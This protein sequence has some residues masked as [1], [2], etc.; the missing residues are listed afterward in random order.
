MPRA[1]PAVRNAARDL[2][3][4]ARP[5]VLVALR[6]R[7][8]GQAR[9]EAARGGRVGPLAQDTLGGQPLLQQ[10]PRRGVVAPA[11]RRPP[12]AEGRQGGRLPVPQ[13]PGDGQ[14]LLEKGTGADLI[15]SLQD[16]DAGA[17]ERPRPRRRAQDRRGRRPR[18]GQ[19]LG[20]AP[21]ALGQVPPQVP[22]AR[23]RRAQ[24][25]GPRRRR[26]VP[27]GRPPHLPPDRGPQVAVLDLQSGEPHR[28]RRPPQ[29]RGRRLRQPQVVGRVPPGDRLCLP[30]RHQPLQGVLP[31]RL[32][33]LEAGVP[34]AV[35]LGEHQRAVDQ[36][37][38]PVQH[39]A[40]RDEP[41]PARRCSS[42]RAHRVGRGRRIGRHPLRRR[43][44][45]AAGEDGQAPEEGPLRLG[46]QGVAPV[47]RRGQGLL[48]GERGAAPA[49]QQAEAV[50]Q[51]TQEVPHRQD[52]RAGGGQLQGQGDPV[53]P[54]AQLGH[55]PRVL[56]AQ[57]EARPGG[58]GALHE[59]SHRLVRG[60]GLRRVR[61]LGRRLQGR[62]APD[63]LTGHPQRLAAR[64][65]DAHAR[66]GAQEGVRQRGAGRHEVLAV[67]Q[68]QQQ[69]LLRQ[70]RRERGRRGLPGTLADAQGARHGLGDEGRVGQR[71]QLDQPHPARVPGQGPLRDLQGEARLAGAPGAGDRQQR[72][73]LEA[74]RQLRERRAAPDEA[75]RR[76]RQVA[77]PAAPRARP[78]RGHAGGSIGPPGGLLGAQ[79]L[80]ATPPER[81]I[82]P[83]AVSE[84]AEDR[85]GLLHRRAD[86]AAVLVLA[87]Q[88]APGGKRPRD[89]PP[90]AEGRR[91]RG[92]RSRCRA[93][94]RR[95]RERQPPPAPARPRGA[96]PDRRGAPRPGRPPPRPRPPRAQGG[97]CPRPRGR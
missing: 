23:Q 2:S 45:P 75:A 12:Q 35:L 63:R 90:V 44:R 11:D 80:A 39:A 42:L 28:P 54:A 25:H 26:R 87:Q 97:S 83:R 91:Q 47:H 5:R 3:W 6:H 16:Q 41:G 58:A 14:A 21:P 89:G 30:V 34:L 62:R 66:A 31:Q 15:A 81:V 52:G 37:G 33:H 71:G 36:P 85:Y 57:R 50:V 72:R 68:H 82:Q 10:G 19:D 70:G 88:G 86:R 17:V 29:V 65:Q 60:Q 95:R 32:Q 55:R 59:E 92:G 79:Q 96:R 7:D 56:G 1:S 74:P 76:A 78:H 9:Q 8:D 22:E 38:Q 43:Q 24:A 77:R 48:P 53:Q 49:G 69:A 73:R 4:S 84:V 20:Q 94:G 46:E 61:A 13:G 40:R 64:G 51:L 67:V 93:R 18:R 27:A